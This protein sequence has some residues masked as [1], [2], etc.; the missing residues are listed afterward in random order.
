[1][2]LS[3]P[4]NSDNMPIDLEGFSQGLYIVEIIKLNGEAVLREKILLK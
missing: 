4:V 1:L 2:I 3:V